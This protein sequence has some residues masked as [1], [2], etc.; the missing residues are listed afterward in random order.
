MEAWRQCLFDWEKSGRD[1]AALA[2]HLRLCGLAEADRRLLVALKSHGQWVCRRSVLQATMRKAAQLAKL[3]VGGTH[4]AKE[5][6]IKP[7]RPGGR[8]MKYEDGVFVVSWSR[9]WGLVPLGDPLADFSEEEFAPMRT[10]EPPEPRGAGANVHA[11]SRER[12]RPYQ[13]PKRSLDPP[14]PN[15]RNQ[16]PDSL[17]NVLGDF[18]G[19][20][21]AAGGVVAL[22]EATLVRSAKS[23]YARVRRVEDRLGVEPAARITPSTA[24]RIALGISEDPD[25]DVA[26]EVERVLGA[27]DAKRPGELRSSPAAYLVGCAK[28]RRWIAGEAAGGY[29]ACSPRVAADEGA[30]SSGG[31]GVGAREEVP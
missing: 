10:A 26:D 4:K 18:L 11:C 19:G 30:Y 23:L 13:E 2:A 3:S 20:V 8:L 7:D 12:S 24:R 22:H 5:R 14:N 1:E 6:L 17:G 21:D 15:P 16:E 27:L 9:V 25:S 31:A 29:G 28:R